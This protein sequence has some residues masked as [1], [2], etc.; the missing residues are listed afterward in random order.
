MAAPHPSSR[1]ATFVQTGNNAFDLR[2]VRLQIQ[3][4]KLKVTDLGGNR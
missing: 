4:L 1:Q 3:S 2:K